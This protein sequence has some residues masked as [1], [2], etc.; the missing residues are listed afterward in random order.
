MEDNKKWE[1]IS[2]DLS[3]VKKNVKDSLNEENIID[4]LKDSLFE[5][6]ENTSK[7]LKTILEN[8]DSTI[9]DDE[10]RKDT[11]EVINKINIEI[12]ET[13][14]SSGLIIKENLFEEE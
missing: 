13:L 12:V 14:K 8:I 1:N 7:L 11:K 4:D 3:K 2:E 9:K 6:L 5:S 10:I